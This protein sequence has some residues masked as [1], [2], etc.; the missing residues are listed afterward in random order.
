MRLRFFVIGKNSYVE[1][2]Y[3]G[4][5]LR[6]VLLHKNTPLPGQPVRPT[7][8]LPRGISKAARKCARAL[9]VRFGVKLRSVDALPESPFDSP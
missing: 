9:H 4:S 1:A 8:R 3:Q 5:N 2:C 6:F 7:S